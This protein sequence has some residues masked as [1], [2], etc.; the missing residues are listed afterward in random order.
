MESY[1]NERFV[2]KRMKWAR[3]TSY[4]AVAALLIGLMTAGRVLWVAYAL[5]LVGLIAASIGAYLTNR[6]IKEP[7]ADKVLASSLESLDK[8]YALYNYYFPAGHLLM[9]H[10]GLT[11]LDPYTMG[12]KVSYQ[13]GHWRHKQG[14]AKIKQLF[15][16]P[17]LGRPEIELRQELAQV[18]K[19][20]DEAMPDQHIPVT[21]VVVFTDPKL[22]LTVEGGDLAV[23]KAD[24]LAQY[25]KVG[26]KG[27]EVLST[28]QQRQLRQM[29]DDAVRAA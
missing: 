25:M 2:A 12:G 3:T 24:G 23:V 27:V 22:E 1:T 11:V 4:V 15:G 13:N 19:W 9:S 7:R 5:L 10:Y 14:L 17:A 21:G 26:P 28:S 18:R 29:L 6:Y 16:D 20:I 8:R